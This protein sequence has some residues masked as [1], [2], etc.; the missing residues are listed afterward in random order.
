MTHFYPA[1]GLW[2]DT[3]AANTEQR[4]LFPFVSFTCVKV[5][6]ARHVSTGQRQQE[7]RRGRET[8]PSRRR[9]CALR[10]L[11]FLRLT[12]P[13]NATI[14]LR[15]VRD[16]GPGGMRTLLSVMFGEGR[17]HSVAEG[18]RSPYALL[19]TGE[20]IPRNFPRT[21]YGNFGPRTTVGH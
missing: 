1:I 6:T 16:A 3:G 18:A 10:L 20:D 8:H 15:R 21:M 11:I 5:L 14:Q 9:S 7:G 17:K 13:L 2:H 12:F 19:A 4:I